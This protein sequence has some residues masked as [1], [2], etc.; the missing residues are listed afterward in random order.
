MTLVDH[1][2]E[3]RRRIFIGVLALVIGSIIGFVI[4]DR[5]AGDPSGADR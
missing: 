1:L 3:L 4:S 2:V 5:R